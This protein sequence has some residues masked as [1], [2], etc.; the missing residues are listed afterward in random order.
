MAWGE[1]TYGSD[2]AFKIDPFMI[3]GVTQHFGL[4]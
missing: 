3:F 4:L 1:N 2:I